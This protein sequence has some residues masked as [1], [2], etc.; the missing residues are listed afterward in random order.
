VESTHIKSRF[1]MSARIYRSRLTWRAS[2]GRASTFMVQSVDRMALVEHEPLV[3][4]PQ[5]PEPMIPRPV[6]APDYAKP[7][8]TD[9]TFTTKGFIPRQEDAPQLHPGSGHADPSAPG[10]RVPHVAGGGSA[11]FPNAR[12]SANWTC[13]AVAHQSALNGGSI[14]KLP[15]SPDQR[16]ARPTAGASLR[17]RDSQA[18]DAT[19]E[20][21]RGVSAQP[22]AA[23]ARCA[24]TR[25]SAVR[26]PLATGRAFR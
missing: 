16:R 17:A 11:P 1:G 4:H 3:M 25:R 23:F 20:C 24:A 13:S 12:Q 21:P 8:E 26:D 15:T 10:A 14:V 7:A 2:I 9:P 6:K 22:P 18:M 5:A 19:F